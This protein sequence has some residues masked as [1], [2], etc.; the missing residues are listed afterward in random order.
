MTGL[1]QGGQRLC[2]AA[3]QPRPYSETLRTREKVAN[4]EPIM[5]KLT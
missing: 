3:D 2:P 5:L 1:G 4:A